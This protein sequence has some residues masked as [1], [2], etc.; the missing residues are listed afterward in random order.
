LEGHE[1][2]YLRGGTDDVIRT[3]HTFSD[4]PGVYIEGKVNVAFDDQTHPRFSPMILYFRSACGSK[5]VFISLKMGMEYISH[6][7][8]GDRLNHRGSPER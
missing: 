4:E 8:W 3:G 1:Q 5:T 2:P 7:M 6:R